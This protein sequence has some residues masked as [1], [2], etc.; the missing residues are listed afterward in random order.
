MS[1][2]FGV[3]SYSMKK[4]TDILKKSWNVLIPGLF[5]RVERPNE[6]RQQTQNHDQN[7]DMSTNN[8]YNQ[9]KTNCTMH[10]IK[11]LAYKQQHA[12]L[13]QVQWSQ[14]QTRLKKSL[15]KTCNKCLS[16][17]NNSTSLR[18]NVT[19][20]HMA[21]RFV[22]FLSVVCRSRFPLLIHDSCRPY[23]LGAS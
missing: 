12:F 22:F 6:D 19:R 18:K 23:T 1:A 3:Q 13:M 17:C 7:N 2:L 15:S 5:S 20:L 8:Y 4:G 14:W 21:N 11:H 16:T 9:V 10:I